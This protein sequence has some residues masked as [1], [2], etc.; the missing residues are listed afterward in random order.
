MSVAHL[1]Q[2]I[3]VA[4]CLAI[5]VFAWRRRHDALQLQLAAYFAFFALVAVGRL[6]LGTVA[7]HFA[8]AEAPRF[9]G[10]GRVLMSVDHALI[11]AS[12]FAFTAITWGAF[13]RR[14]RAWLL[15]SVVAGA[16]LTADLATYGL[17][18]VAV[19]FRVV[20]AGLPFATA[21]ELVAVALAWRN[22]P[23]DLRLAHRVVL[24]FVATDVTLSLM[25]ELGPKDAWLV[26]SAINLITFGFAAVAYALEPVVA[27]GI[28]REREERWRR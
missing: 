17:V 24:F 3:E 16:L 9:R 26:Q 4:E 8:Y 13:V 11:L 7:T 25:R 6:F 5:A 21:L 10:F 15:P 12:N 14:E 20:N 18:P 27:V 1:A 23:R 2:V 19:T 28:E 22:P